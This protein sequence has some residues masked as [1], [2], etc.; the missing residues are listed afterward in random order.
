MFPNEPRNGTRK[1][2][3]NVSAHGVVIDHIL[4]DEMKG[5]LIVLFWLCANAA[6]AQ[7]SA[8]ATGVS[9]QLYAS[10]DDTAKIFHN[11][12]EIHTATIPVSSSNE[13]TL[14]AGDRLVAQLGNN[15]G[16]RRF[17]MIFV[18][19]DRRWIISFDK[20][21]YRVLDVSAI[22]FVAGDWGK[23]TKRARIPPAP[24]N[25]IFPYRN[26]ADWVWG[27]DDSCTLGTLIGVELFKPLAATAAQMRD[28]G[29]I[30]LTVEALVDGPSTLYVRKDGL[31]WVNGGNA[32]PGL[33]EEP[34]YVDDKPWLPKWGDPER[35][36]GADRT[37]VFSITLPSL[38]L[39]VDLVSNMEKR[40]AEG[41]DTSRRPIDAKRRGNEIIILIPDPEPGARWYKIVFR[42]RKK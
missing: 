9:G 18:S 15:G 17:R 28:E 30:V 35:K 7:F 37:D 21:N 16:P 38:D 31:L 34:T 19:T 6:M 29:R 1:E 24:A 14:K 41:I 13:F 4:L 39:K 22:D 12:K 42:D 26:S 23:M 32:K 3:L 40:G 5:A 11:G 2:L 8:P 36:R 25:E 10:A 33:S 27:D 20:Q